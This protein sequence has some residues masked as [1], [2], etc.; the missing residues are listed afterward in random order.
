MGPVFL[1]LFKREDQEP[2]FRVAESRLNFPGNVS[3]GQV[4]PSW[5]AAT[6]SSGAYRRPGPRDMSMTAGAS[7]IL[8]VNEIWDRKFLTS[9][10]FVQA[11]SSAFHINGR[12]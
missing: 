6:S 1:P 2:K 4:L 5:P 3:S 10:V 11:L 12:P 8:E 9:G 7:P